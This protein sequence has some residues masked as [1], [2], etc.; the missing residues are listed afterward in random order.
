MAAAAAAAADIV[1]QLR[2]S[3]LHRLL[4][5]LLLRP[6]AELLREFWEKKYGKNLREKVRQ[7]ITFVELF[8]L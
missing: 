7:K 6:N 4:L 2:R 1:N 3:L 8:D 5:P